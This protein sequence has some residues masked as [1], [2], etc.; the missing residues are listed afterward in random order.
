MACSGGG[1]R[2]SVRRGTTLEKIADLPAL[3]GHD[4]T[5]A[6]LSLLAL[7]RTLFLQSGQAFCNMCM[8]MCISGVRR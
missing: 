4:L 2:T 1:P 5:S 8:Y 3:R 7:E 6:G